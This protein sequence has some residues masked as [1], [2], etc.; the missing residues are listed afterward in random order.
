V[1][2]IVLVVALLAV[3]P[4]TA[5]AD[6]VLP[7]A[8][9]DAETGDLTG[10]VAS[11]PSFLAIRASEGYPVFQGTWSFAAGSGGPGISEMWQDI[12]LTPDESCIDGGECSF[13]LSGWTRTDPG[14]SARVLLEFKR[15]GLPDYD[16]D[17]DYYVS[18]GVWTGI[19]ACGQSRW[20]GA[21][22]GP[23]AV[24]T[25]MVRITL[26]GKSASTNGESWIGAYFDTIQLAT[27][28]GSGM[29]ARP[30]T[31]GGLKALYR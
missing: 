20:V 28:F 29:P 10:W 23:L 27:F 8:N 14:D 17:S 21:S 15:P 26:F 16:C 24:G 3:V 5:G 6:G 25:R 22:S 12:D 30:Q 19:P 13:A 4:S 18:D 2:R 1:K 31:W 11:S 7:F 9:P